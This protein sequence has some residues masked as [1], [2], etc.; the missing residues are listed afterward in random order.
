ML[1]S[2]PQSDIDAFKDKIN[3]I[4]FDAVKEYSAHIQ[5]ARPR[6]LLRLELSALLEITQR[7][8]GYLE[9]GTVP[10]QATAVR[11]IHQRRCPER[12]SKDIIALVHLRDLEQQR[13]QRHP[14]ASTTNEHH[15]R[16]VG[17]QT[18]YRQALCTSCQYG[19]RARNLVWPDT[20]R[21]LS[22]L[23]TSAPTWWLWSSGGSGR[24]RC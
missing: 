15:V 4:T 16:V 10:G 22:M 3:N 14:L 20:Q 11:I 5:T 12:N 24:T 2:K 21:R 8:R 17:W 18:A 6:S 19:W 13:S 7:E 9:L 23:W 1:S